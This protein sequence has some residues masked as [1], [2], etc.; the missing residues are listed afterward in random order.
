M[1]VKAN[2]SFKTIIRDAIQ[3]ALKEINKPT[4]TIDECKE[5]SGIGR[6]K[7]MELVHAENSDF[8]CF[9]NGNKFLINKKKL[10]L[11]LEKVSEEKRI[12]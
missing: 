12:L 4:M 6:D 9:R 10:D 5:Y 8:P 11:W 3:E 1:E 7:L 2:E